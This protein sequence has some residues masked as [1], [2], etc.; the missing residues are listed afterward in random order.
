MA[1][2]DP[3]APG[4]QKIY[5]PRMHAPQPKVAAKLIVSVSL[6]CLGTPWRVLLPA[7]NLLFSR[8]WADAKDTRQS[9]PMILNLNICT[10]LLI[11]IS[12]MQW[13][14]YIRFGNLLVQL[15]L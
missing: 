2:S 10:L 14:D 12:L 6:Y 8:T 1:G 3:S 9:V 15:I 11:I 7:R 5:P 13:V 4:I